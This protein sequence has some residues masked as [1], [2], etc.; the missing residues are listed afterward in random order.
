[1]ELPDRIFDAS[2]ILI[3][4]SWKQ[5]FDSSDLNAMFYAPNARTLV[6]RGTQP[7]ADY[8]PITLFASVFPKWIKDNKE[9]PSAAFSHVTV[10][11]TDYDYITVGERHNL[12]IGDEVTITYSSAGYTK[13]IVGVS[14][15]D[16][17]VTQFTTDANG[18]CDVSFDTD[19]QIVDFPE[20]YMEMLTLEIKRRM[21]ARKGLQM[22]MVEYSQLQQ[23]IARWQ[24]EQ[25][26]VA[27]ASHMSVV[28]YGFGK[29]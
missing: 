26:R 14:D 3:S 20:N 6:Y 28:G 7:I 11:G 24:A 10:D 1:L 17:I 21:Y 5:L 8:N 29:R 4:S 23:L 19:D 22:S 13:T 25:G 12:E 18:I 2:S 27:R 15:T 9:F 16:I